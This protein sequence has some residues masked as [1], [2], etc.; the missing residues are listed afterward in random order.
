MLFSTPKPF[1][2]LFLLVLTGTLAHAT[3]NDLRPPPTKRI[4][5]TS[6]FNVKNPGQTPA[7]KVPAAP[8]ILP[9][10]DVAG[11]IGA[12]ISPSTSLLMRTAATLLSTVSTG[13][14][15]G[16]VQQVV[17]LVPGLLCGLFG[18][19]PQATT[20]AVPKAVSTAVSIVREAI[21]CLD[22]THNETTINSLF[23]YG[24]AGTTVYLC[25]NAVI[26]IQNPI[27]FSAA[28]QVLTTKGLPIGDTRA[29]IQ[30]QGLAQTC[31]IYGAC[32]SCGGISLTNVIVYG[33]RPG[34]GWVLNGLGLIEM[35]GSTSGQT[36]D[37]IKSY[38]PRSWTALHLIEG[39]ANSCSGATV[40]NSQ[41]G[42]S[43]HGPS[44][45][46]QFKM[47]RQRRDTGTYTPGQWA[48]GISLACKNSTV[49]G[50][51]ITDA[52]DGGIVIFGA[53]GSRITGNTIIST[54]RNLLGGINSVDYS[55]F[56]GD[57]TGTVVSGNTIN[58]QSAMIKVGIAIGPLTWSSL[59]STAFRNK[60]GQW[61]GNT[62]TS[63]STG[64]FN[65]G[66]SVDGHTSP[67]VIGNVFAAAN[68]G[69]T[70]GTA[71]TSVNPAF[72]PAYINQY[73]T[74][75]PNV[76]SSVLKGGAF[77]FMTCNAP[78]S[79]SRAAVTLGP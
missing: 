56:N 54:S 50:N 62:F 60:N 34:L 44:G 63:G 76:Q 6:P 53:P 22:S 8:V 52:T 77:Q 73:T 26:N 17:N 55:P 49:I 39:N 32:T 37:N 23:Y 24:G 1:A 58:A 36:I 16:A 64:Y 31:A 15:A 33:N 30:V 14:V 10:P 47:H 20:A 61:S 19:A 70:I 40:S 68:F 57:Y 3:D 38:E 46:Q 79:I 41:I 29:T 65:Y 25:A 42:P 75:N 27:Q 4:D 18:C 21:D 72:G 43:G 11:L 7:F 71:C 66:I 74:T 59:N 45:T 13:N 9:I 78:G 28:N 2:V 69:G 51:T 35:G 12:V 48:D 5:L 67:T